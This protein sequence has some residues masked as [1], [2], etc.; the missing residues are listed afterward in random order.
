[1]L[2]GIRNIKIKIPMKFNREWKIDTSFFDIFGYRVHER[3]F[4]RNCWWC[5][6]KWRWY[7]HTKVEYSVY[8]I[9][10]IHCYHIT[11]NLNVFCKNKLILELRCIFTL[12]HV[13]YWFQNS[14]NPWDALYKYNIVCKLTPLLFAEVI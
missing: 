3:A 12:E 1:M 14:Q 8:N 13:C 7:C 9:Y 2:V 6:M 11:H 10:W 4:S 5:Y